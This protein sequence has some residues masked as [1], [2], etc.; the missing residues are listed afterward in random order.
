[1]QFKEFIAE[2]KSSNWHGIGKMKREEAAKILKWL[3]DAQTPL[4]K[5]N[6][7]L[8]WLIPSTLTHTAKIKRFA[9]FIPFH[10]IWAAIQLYSIKIY[11]IV[12]YRR[13]REK[14]MRKCPSYP[15]T[16]KF[17]FE[18]T[19]LCRCQFFAIFKWGHPHLHIFFGSDI[20]QERERKTSD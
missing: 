14:V 3:V 6:S 19:S 15:D 16:V 7:Y 20:E 2:F 5:M 13:E 17:R 12:F 8:N 10:L 9:N 4:Y 1:M 11:N 18:F